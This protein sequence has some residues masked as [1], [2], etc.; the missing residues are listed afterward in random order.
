MRSRGFTT[1]EVLVALAILAISL[2]AAMRAGELGIAG[3]D[4]TRQRILADWVA[5]DR[6]AELQAKHAWPDPG[7][8]EGS[9]EQNGQEFHWRQKVVATPNNKFRRVAVEVVDKDGSVLGEIVGM[10][11]QAGRS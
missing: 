11:W 8:S 6:L 2:S 4:Q 7:I 5:S 3:F 10:L 1:V 9:A